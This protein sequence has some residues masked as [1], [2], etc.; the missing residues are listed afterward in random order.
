MPLYIYSNYVN[1]TVYGN[2]GGNAGCVGC[3]VAIIDTYTFTKFLNGGADKPTRSMF[4]DIHTTELCIEGCLFC[5]QW[6]IYTSNSI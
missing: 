3:L 6:G 5:T 2:S 1:S 4:M